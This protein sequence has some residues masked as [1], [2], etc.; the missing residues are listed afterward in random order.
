M[1]Q[2]KAFGSFMLRGS[3]MFR[4]SAYIQWR[5]S[6][7]SLGA[8]L[9]L[10]P[11][12]AGFGAD[13]PEL[14]ERLARLG[15][16][17]GRIQPDATMHQLI[18]F[19]EKI[20]EDRS[21]PEGRLYIYNLFNLQETNADA[22]AGKFE[23]LVDSGKIMVNEALIS[24][25]ELQRHPWILIG[26]GV[27][28]DNKRPHLQEIKRRWLAQIAAAGIPAF[29]KQNDKGDYYHP[30]PQ[31]RAGQGRLLDELLALYEK[32][33]PFLH[34]KKESGYT[35]LKWNGRHGE[36][37]QFIVRDNENGLQSLAGAGRLQDLVWFH[38][39]LAG[40][41]AVSGWKTFDK[42]GFDDLSDLCK[43]T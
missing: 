30:C 6:P 11:G 38:L 18:R 1:N 24:A 33:L 17:M 31:L 22:A 37:A 3:H 15:A 23:T 35:C 20:H 28:N 36:K 32:V 8:V 19:I 9:M 7:A 43:M 26:W 10:N 12:S 25:G 39:D 40:D 5:Q 41:P 21:S 34:I 16:A 4:T 29:G 27:I 42:K 13:N 14:K 2:P